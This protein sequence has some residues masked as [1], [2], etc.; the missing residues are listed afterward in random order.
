MNLSDVEKQIV[1]LQVVFTHLNMLKNWSCKIVPRALDAVEIK[2]LEC[3]FVFFLYL[4][5]R[6]TTIEFTIS[7]CKENYCYKVRYMHM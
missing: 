5:V 3:L 7:F 2:F 6:T 4:C 1:K